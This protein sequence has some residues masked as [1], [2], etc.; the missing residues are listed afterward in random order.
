MIRNACLHA[1]RASGSG[2]ARLVRGERGGVM[3]QR[4]G[5]LGCE[6]VTDHLT[7]HKAS[8]APM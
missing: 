6:A 1:Q 7:A 3:D 2:R 5:K 4:L 8:N